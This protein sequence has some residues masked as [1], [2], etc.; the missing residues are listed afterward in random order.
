MP[1]NVSLRRDA[2]R[3]ARL[4]VWVLSGIVAMQ[5]PALAAAG[6]HHVD[7]PAASYSINDVGAPGSAYSSFSQVIGFNNTGQFVGDAY[8]QVTYGNQ[9]SYLQCIAYTGTAWVPLQGPAVTLNCY[10]SSGISDA[11]K[12]GVFT[13]VGQ[14]NI[15]TAYQP[16]AFYST[17][18]PTSAKTKIFFDNQVSGLY[19]ENKRGLAAGYTSYKPVG[20]SFST[21]LPSV[22]STGKSLPLFQPQCTTPLSGCAGAPYYIGWGYNI[23]G[24]FITAGGTVF[25]QPLFGNSAYIEYTGG[26]NPTALQVSIPPDGSNAAQGITGID[27]NGNVTYFEYDT[28]LAE[29]LT[30]IYNPKTQTATNLGTLAGS[31]CTSWTP[32]WINGP[33]RVLGTAQNCSVPSDATYWTWDSTNGM[34]AVSFNGTGYSSIT[35]RTINDLGEISVDLA[36]SGTNAHHW[37][38]LKPPSPL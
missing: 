22:T 3:A 14:L 33:G 16:M 28:N 35:A 17:V 31:S 29:N 30:W 38:Y 15:P 24:R 36:V 18:S 6:R 32:L 11:N 10:A 34:V 8:Q 27:D 1:N 9:F 26:N 37:G 7:Y 23:G 12:A 19:L 13:T 5:G 21:S 4:S 25:L 2:P 20:S